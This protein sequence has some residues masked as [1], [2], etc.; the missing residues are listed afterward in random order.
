MIQVI[1]AYGQTLIDI[2]LQELGDVERVFE[3]AALN[4]K[5]ITDTVSAGDL[6]IVPELDASKR[7]L[8]KLFSDPF[9]KPASSTGFIA[10]EDYWNFPKVDKVTLASFVPI[11]QKKVFVEEGQTVID[12]V[13]QEL[14]D[15]ERIFEVAKLNGLGITDELAPGSY[16]LVPTYNQDKREIVRVFSDPSNKP[17]SRRRIS[18]IEVVLQQG[19]DYWAVNM[20]FIVS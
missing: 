15:A 18:D 19:I 14:G 2:T 5:A 16:L 8:V 17:A 1:A 4:G 9:N 3:V 13:L 20:D 6:I 7:K 10:P 12:I 11:G